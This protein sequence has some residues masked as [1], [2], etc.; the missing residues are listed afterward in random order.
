MAG[1]VGEYSEGDTDDSRVAGTHAIHAIIE[2]TA[3][4]HCHHYEGGKEDK[5]YP[6]GCTLVLSEPCKHGGI[7]EIIMLYERNI[8][9]F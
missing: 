9:R 8:F 5:E 3:I 6:S 7:V 1:D 4:A 2:V